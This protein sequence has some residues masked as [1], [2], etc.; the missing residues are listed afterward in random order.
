MKLFKKALGVLLVVAM[1]M[2]VCAVM[3]TNVATAYTVKDNNLLALTFDDEKGLA[4][5]RAKSGGFDFSFEEGVQVDGTTGKYPVFTH[6]SYQGWSV[7]FGNED[8]VAAVS[9]PSAAHPNRFTVPAAG[10]YTF[11]YSYKYLAGA[12]QPNVTED[13]VASETFYVDFYKCAIADP[14][15]KNGLPGK[16]HLGGKGVLK[17]SSLTEGVDYKIVDDIAID[18]ET[19]YQR[20]E[21][22]KDTQ[23]FTTSFDITFSETDITAGRTSICLT[24]NAGTKDLIGDGESDVEFKVAIDNVNISHAGA[25]EAATSAKTYVYDFKDAAG[26]P[27]TSSFGGHTN[28]SGSDATGGNTCSGLCRYGHE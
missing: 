15:V 21:L 8:S 20:V 24:F 10:T 17:V 14:T 16:A 1:L 4:D 2:S 12:S 28:F 22:I 23:W 9:D 7:V 5:Y 19:E 3:F 18:G 13:I 11:T 25:A 27:D 6:K 26:N